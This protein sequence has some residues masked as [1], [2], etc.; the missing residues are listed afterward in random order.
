MAKGSGSA[1]PASVI[2]LALLCLL[3]QSEI[4]H[5]AVYTV[6]DGKG[7]TLNAVNWPNGKHFKAGDVLVFKYNSAA[8]NVV[9]VNAAGYNSC[10]TPRGARVL[11]TGNDRVKLA[12]GKNYFICNFPGHCEAGMKIAVTAA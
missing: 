8:H 7:W 12:R 4:A 3:I 6:G 10:K 2:G 5:A 1:I 9:P 11:K